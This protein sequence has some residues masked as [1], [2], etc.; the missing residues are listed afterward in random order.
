MDLVK[1]LSP[2][3]VILVH[4]EKPKMVSLKERV[5]SELEIR[6]YVPAN[7]ETVHIPSTIFVKANAS[8]AFI[9]SCLSPNFRFINQSLEDTSDLV[10]ESTKATCRLQVSDDRV[11]EGIL[12]MEKNKK[13]RV[14]HQDELLLM[15][16]EKQQEVR[17]AYCCPVHV[18]NLDSLSSLS[19][20][21]LLSEKC[22]W[23]QQLFTKLSNDFPGRSI[24][25]FGEYLQVES[26]HLS[27]CLKDDCPY[28][29]I[30][31]GKN[32]AEV[33]FCCTWSMNDEKFA[34]E[35]I[36]TIKKCHLIVE[37]FNPSA[38]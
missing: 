7:S 6:C 11:G 15:M 2:K 12:V 32:T 24:Q 13:A 38:D 18:V 35:I 1:F 23:L 37:K 19:D 5:Q 3:H 30:G 8:D 20:E 34:R 26:F 9:H 4:G 21:L 28:R 22:S 17:F 31:S 10:L 36:S 25:N 27:T 16:G 33:L 14:V 29:K